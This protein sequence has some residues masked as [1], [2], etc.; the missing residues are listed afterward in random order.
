MK[1]ENN[2]TMPLSQPLPRQLLHQR[3][4][5]CRGYRRD[6]GLFDTD[7]CHALRSGGEVVKVHW[8]AYYTGT[9]GG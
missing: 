7:T 2:H 5:I 4:V 1:V 6:D 9:S 8:P 3:T